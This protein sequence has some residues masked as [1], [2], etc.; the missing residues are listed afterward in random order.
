[1][2]HCFEV[3]TIESAIRKRIVSQVRLSSNLHPFYQNYRLSRQRYG[4]QDYTRSAPDDG[5]KMALIPSFPQSPALFF[6]AG[7]ARG[8]FAEA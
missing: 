1:M 5:S 4:H 7:S 8:D 3:S 6:A 2:W